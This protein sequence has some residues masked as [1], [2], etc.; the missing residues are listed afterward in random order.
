LEEASSAADKEVNRLVLLRG[1][2][3]DEMLRSPHHRWPELGIELDLL[4]AQVKAAFVA[5]A[6][7]RAAMVAVL[8]DPSY[9]VEGPEEPRWF[10]PENLH[11]MLE[12]NLPRSR[13][14]FAVACAERLAPT[15]LKHCEATGRGDPSTLERILRGAW[16]HLSGRELSDADV[17]ASLETCMALTPDEDGEWLSYA[18]DATSSCGHA[19]R[20]LI[21]GDAPEA[22][23]AARCAY[24]AVARFVTERLGVPHVDAARESLVQAEVSRQFRD[25]YEELAPTEI[26]NDVVHRIRDLAKAEGPA[27]FGPDGVFP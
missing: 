2:L 20:T 22:V 3:G 15:Y 12:C 27:L 17:A 8:E 26:D 9:W 24:S 19:L 13:A 23:H 16:D 4:D 14:V 25:L 6:A 21:S 1:R 7:A 5:A 11:A 18:A 10:K